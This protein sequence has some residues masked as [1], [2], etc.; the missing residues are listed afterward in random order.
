MQTALRC[1]V[2]LF[3]MSAVFA[4]EKPFHLVAFGDSITGDRPGKPYLHQYLKWSNLLGLM[5]EAKIGRAVTVTNA[6]YAG[7]KTFKSGD[8]PG[9]IHRFAAQALESKPDLVVMLIGGNDGDK[10]RDE[11]EQNLHT[12]VSQAK[13]AG[14]PLVLLA[15]HDAQEPEGGNPEAWRHLSG[16]NDLIR[17][18]AEKGGVPL[19]ELQPAFAEARA[20]GV[21][22]NALANAKDGVHLAPHGEIVVARAV[23]QGLVQHNIFAE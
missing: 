1:L 20:A 13:A 18:A 15:Y 2:G 8:R 17:K 19:V 3:I 9:A 21:A 14:V 16:N 10:K 11:T 7:D 6:G 22:Y 23:F 5:V 12:M 4:E